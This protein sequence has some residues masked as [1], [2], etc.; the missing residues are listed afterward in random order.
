MNWVYQYYFKT[1]CPS[2]EWAYP[3]LDPPA[4]TDL[5]EHFKYDLNSIEFP[6]ST[7]INPLEQLMV[8]L[9]PDSHTLLPKEYGSLMTEDSSPLIENYPKNIELDSLHKWKYYQCEP[10]LPLLDIPNLKRTVKT[11][12]LQEKDKRRNE[13]ETPIE[14]VRT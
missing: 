8:V 13:L 3:Y 12:P 14:I 10:I 5:V 7:P 2:W 6:P 4:I 11:I 9:P 1:I